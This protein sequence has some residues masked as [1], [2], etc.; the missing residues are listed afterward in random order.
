ML[1]N[2]FFFVRSCVLERKKFILVGFCHLDR[3]LLV[4]YKVIVFLSS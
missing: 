3:I 4:N 2:E 1:K